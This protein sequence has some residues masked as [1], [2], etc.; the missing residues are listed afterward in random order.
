MA[1]L[2]VVTPPGV[3]PVEV[4]EL[5]EYLKLPDVPEDDA[6]LSSFI[7]A[8]VARVEGYLNRALI[9]RTVKESSRRI[10]YFSN[11]RT[12]LAPVS[13]VSEILLDGTELDADNYDATDD[14]GG[15]IAFDPFAGFTSVMQV[16][17]VAG[18][19]PAA[20]DVPPAIRTAILRD[21]AAMYLDP[22]AG[23]S[24]LVAGL[25]SP[26]RRIFF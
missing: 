5:S 9:S 1:S 15:V 16:T 10:G 23:L 14:E 7:D 25:C 26:Y 21:A 11:F 18:Y 24:T 6:R 4:E 13:S 3:R 22:A 19:G 20:S 12:A 2:T 8:A 17:Y